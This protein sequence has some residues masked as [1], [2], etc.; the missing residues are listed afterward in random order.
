MKRLICRLFVAGMMVFV[1]A[2][3]CPGVNPIDWTLKAAK[4]ERSG[5]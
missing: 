2:F 3:S 4:L 5:G 1:A